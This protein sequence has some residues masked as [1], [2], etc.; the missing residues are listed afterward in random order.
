[1]TEQHTNISKRI[2]YV[3]RHRPDSVALVLEDNGW[4]GVDALLE[5]ASK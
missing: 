3:L 1:M 2:S 5:H 4:I